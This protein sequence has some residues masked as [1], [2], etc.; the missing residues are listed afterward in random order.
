[1]PEYLSIDRQ[2][3]G[4]ARLTLN[5]KDK[6]NRF[7]GTMVNELIT[8]LRELEEDHSLRALVITSS[9]NCFCQGADLEWVKEAQDHSPMPHL[10]PGSRIIDALHELDSFPRPVVA[11]VNGD[12]LGAGAGL[13]ACSDIVI[14][15]ESSKIAF[16]EVTN[17][18]V[19]GAAAVYVSNVIGMHQ[20]KRWLLTGETMDAAQAHDIGLVHITV[21]DEEL[22]NAVNAQVDLLLHGGPRAQRETKSLLRQLSDKDKY[23]SPGYRT[24]FGSIFQRCLSSKEGKN[25]IQAAIDNELPRWAPEKKQ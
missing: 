12:A 14:A 1:M 21:P 5:N 18:L 24:G 4:V 7:N 20:A 19:P 17:G 6:G 9:G 2:D 13:L 15:C 10:D 3:N 25:G 11:R 22:D 16:H 8:A 23:Q